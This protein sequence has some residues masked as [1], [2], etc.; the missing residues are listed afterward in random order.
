MAT[1]YD[2]SKT[3]EGETMTEVEIRKLLNDY[4]NYFYNNPIMSLKHLKD[5][6]RPDGMEK[7]QFSLP[8]EFIR[9]LPDA[10]MQDTSTKKKWASYMAL[11]LILHQMIGSSYGTSQESFDVAAWRLQTGHSEE[12]LG[13]NKMKPIDK[14]IMA[15]VDLNAIL[16]VDVKKSLNGETKWFHGMGFLSDFSTA[17]LTGHQLSSRTGGGAIKLEVTARDKTICVADAV[18][19]SL[20]WLLNQGKK[21]SSSMYDFG[22]ANLKEPLYQLPFLNCVTTPDTPRYPDGVLPGAVFGHPDQFPK[23]CY[24]SMD[25]KFH[26]SVPIGIIHHNGDT[27][28]GNSGS[29]VTVGR[30]AVGIHNGWQWLDK[31]KTEKINVATPINHYGNDV[32]IFRHILDY[33]AIMPTLYETLKESF[34]ET[35]KFLAI[36]VGGI[37]EVEVVGHI[38]GETRAVHFQW[39]EVEC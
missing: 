2:S 29:P 37:A 15:E 12:L 17:M 36:R 24:A 28:K 27:I 1:T 13:K 4:T 31:E 35:A 6:Y 7:L 3:A 10:P 14:E 33:M 30:N 8:L 23:L 22:M 20:H 5:G 9:A 18:A 34:S 21:N 16:K 32:K 39:R 26:H 19:V 25:I 11:Q 38:K